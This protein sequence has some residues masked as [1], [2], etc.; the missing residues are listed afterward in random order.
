MPLGIVN[1]SEFEAESRNSHAEPVEG[2]VVEINRGRGH[3]PEVPNG[4]RKIIGETSEIDGRDEALKLAQSFGIS[5]SSVS[6]YAKGAT[7]TATINDATPNLS[8]INQAKERIT[9]KA[10]SKLL[11]ALHH[12][13]DDKLSAAKVETLSGVARDMSAVIKNMEPD[14]PKN[15]NDSSENRPQFTFYAPTFIKEEHFD[16]IYAKE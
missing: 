2:K 13:T 16:T 3:N 6:A 1:D 4:L 9:K 11:R 5:P 7:S 12:I 15:S 8:H 10:R 14:V